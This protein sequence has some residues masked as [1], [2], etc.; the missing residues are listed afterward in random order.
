MTSSIESERLELISMTPAFLQAS[1][2]GK[3]HE[4]EKQLGLALPA[5]WPGEHEDVLSLRLKQLDE[6]P[7]LQPWLIRAMALRESRIMIGT[8]GFHSAPGAD[9]LKSFCPGA[10]E[11]GFT[12]F[13]PYRRRGF[14][15][16]AS[17]AL[18]RWA[19]EVH[20]VKSFVLSIRPDNAPS[21][22]L[23]A[24]LGFVCIGSHMDEVDGLEDVLEYKA[25]GEES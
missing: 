19:Q 21:Q 7:S 4:A 2:E 3:L 18:M 20:G 17:I 1:L 22:A 8:I 16:E 10:V 13:P 6:D 14:A 25:L 9:Y 5:Q 23:A 11:F 15:R 24:H 12:V